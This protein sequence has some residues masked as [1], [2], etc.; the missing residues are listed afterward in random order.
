MLDNYIE[1]KIELLEDENKRK[2]SAKVG[3]NMLDLPDIETPEPSQRIIRRVCLPRTRPRG[4]SSPGQEDRPTEVPATSVDRF[5]LPTA[6][7][8][9]TSTEEDKIVVI[10]PAVE[11]GTQEQNQSLSGI[12]S[13]GIS[14]GATEKALEGER[15]AILDAVDTGTTEGAE[16]QQVLE[17]MENKSDCSQSMAIRGTEGET[18]DP[19]NVADGPVMSQ[20]N[21]TS[22]VGV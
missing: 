4:R 8:C 10:S 9:I 20:G 18:N 6:G 7:T 3:E 19:S 12:K 5:Y 15:R 1:S 2:E 16:K 11:L 21:K 14:K 13:T 17:I 22:R